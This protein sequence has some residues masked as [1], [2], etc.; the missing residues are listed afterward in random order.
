MMKHMTENE[1]FSGDPSELPGLQ[2]PVPE[3]R[4]P[5]RGYVPEV[6]DPVIDRIRREDEGIDDVVPQDVPK[7]DEVIERQ[8]K[9]MNMPV[10]G[11]D[12]EAYLL[13]MEQSLVEANLNVERIA[14]LVGAFGEQPVWRRFLHHREYV[15]LQ[16]EYAAAIEAAHLAENA[17]RISRQSVASD[18][19]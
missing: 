16:R 1:H 4:I 11:E 7:I 9:K 13:K 8:R 5:G 18:A 12:P 14:M 19:M 10:A 3:I 2:L 15:K 6:G 17:I